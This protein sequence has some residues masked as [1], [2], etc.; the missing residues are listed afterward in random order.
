MKKAKR[1]IAEIMLT[2]MVIVGAGVKPPDIFV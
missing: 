1:L 2:C